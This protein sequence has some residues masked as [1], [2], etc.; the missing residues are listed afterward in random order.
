ME[1]QELYRLEN[2]SGRSYESISPTEVDL[3]AN[4]SQNI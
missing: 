4:S 3:D 1:A 2:V